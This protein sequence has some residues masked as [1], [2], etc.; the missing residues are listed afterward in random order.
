[1]PTAPGTYRATYRLQGPRG[2]FGDSFWVQITVQ[3]STDCARYVADLNY[4][5][6]TVVARGATINKR[7]RLSN[8]GNTTWG[9]GFSAVRTAGAYGPGSFGVPTVSP[10]ANGDLSVNMTVPSTP[11][12]YRAT[13]RMQGPRGQFGESFWV[14]IRVQ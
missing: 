8:C 9:A 1:V 14:Q 2:Q 13:Y 5:D 4:P 7:W 3:A 10:G 12:T 11:G 6:N